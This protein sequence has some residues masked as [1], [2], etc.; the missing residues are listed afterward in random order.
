MTQSAHRPRKR[1]GQN[2]LTDQSVI[3][4]TVHAI[5]PK[6]N[7]LL[8][9]IGPGQGAL[10][11]PL[12]QHLDHLHVVEIDRDLVA[13]LAKLPACEAGKLTIHEADAL[14]FDF[15][16]LIKDSQQLRIVGNLPYNI[17]SPLLFHLLPLGLKIRDMHFMLQREVV[18]RMAATPGSK[19]YG[20]LSVM[21]QVM[22]DVESLIDVPPSAFEPAPKVDSAIVRLNPRPLL[23]EPEVALQLDKVVKAAFAQRRKTL[24]NSLAKIMAATE[25]ANLGID[26]GL[27]AE[28]LSV[29]EFLRIAKSLTGE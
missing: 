3:T 9:E 23:E 15:S 29:D 16:S 24:R 14:K 7:D 6:A 1:F 26:A 12:L 11:L 8:V 20:R 22:C 2:F 5:A 21:V 4:D 10:T 27:R 18:Q 13:Q 17:S 28:M 25:L 19:A